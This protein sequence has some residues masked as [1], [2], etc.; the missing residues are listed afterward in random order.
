MSENVF[1]ATSRYD[2]MTSSNGNDFYDT[3]PKRGESTTAGFDVFFS[4]NLNK[5]LKKQSSCL[6]FEMLWC[7]LWRHSNGIRKD[8]NQVLKCLKVA[9]YSKWFLQ[10]M[11]SKTKLHNLTNIM[12][13]S[14]NGS[15]FRVTGH[16]AGNSPVSG[17]FPTQRPVMQSFDVYFDLRPNTR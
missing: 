17:E 14:S 3:D 2:M 13:T 8:K 5:R 15:I 10:K 6:W 9:R 16:C 12:M 1:C 4:V 7:S 11:T